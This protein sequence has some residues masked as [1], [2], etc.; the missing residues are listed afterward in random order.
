MFPLNSMNVNILN[1]VGR[2]DIYLKIQ[3]FVQLL[4]IP[5]IFV[6]IYL[7]VKGLIV[8]MMVISLLGYFIFNRESKKIIHYSIKDQLKDIMPSF[9]L[10][11]AMG[12]VVYLIGLFSRLSPLPTFL[13][14]IFSGFITV[15]LAGEIF[16]L[17]EY[18]FVK[19]V[20]KSK[21]HFPTFF[22][23]LRL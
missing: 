6:G 5:N 8:G 20:F 16:E 12:V 1:V 4:I 15:V 10:S 23:K 11:V 13:I 3:F 2:S 7:G 17:K 21:V 19:H 22:K 18:L 14:Q 9:L